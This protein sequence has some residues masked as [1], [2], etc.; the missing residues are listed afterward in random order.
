MALLNPAY[1]PEPRPTPT[2]RLV[3]LVPTQVTQQRVKPLTFSIVLVSL[4][5]TGLM[6]LLIINT[7]LT[8]NSFTLHDLQ[9]QSRALSDRE[10][11]LSEQLVRTESPE[12][13]AARA[14]ALGMVPS[15]TTT[16]LTLD[17]VGS[18]D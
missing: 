11:A 17:N 2:V 1:V 4:L 15:A 18:A 3:A 5:I 16:F 9:Q 6:S 10:Q 14:G 8:A 7:M 13:L 12:S